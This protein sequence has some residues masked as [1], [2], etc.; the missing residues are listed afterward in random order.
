L[1]NVNP[2]N[3]ASKKTPPERDNKTM[4]TTLT[5]SDWEEIYYALDSKRTAIGKAGDTCETLEEE[6][7]W[8]NQI[9]ELMQKIGPDCYSAFKAQRI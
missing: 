3:H 2:R 9:G 4:A 1:R 5:Q 7:C 6:E 8:S